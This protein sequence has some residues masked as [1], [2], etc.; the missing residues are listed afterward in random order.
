MLLLWCLLPPGGYLL[1]STHLQALHGTQG[2]EGGSAATT[3]VI[4][5]TAQV[6]IREGHGDIRYGLKWPPKTSEGKE[7]EWGKSRTLDLGTGPELRRL[8]AG[9]LSGE[10]AEGRAATTRKGRGNPQL[11]MSIWPCLSAA[12]SFHRGDPVELV[13]ASSVF[14]TAQIPRAAPV[15]YLCSLGTPTWLHHTSLMHGCLWS[16]I[17]PLGQVN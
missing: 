6:N 3:Q 14:P 5:G 1:E 8:D 4:G 11:V 10:E 16:H 13:L 9:G 17:H 12:V 2:A 15:L 7:K